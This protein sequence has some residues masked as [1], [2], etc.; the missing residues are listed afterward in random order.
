MVLKHSA[1]IY[2]AL[3][4]GGWSV[5]T[6]LTHDDYDQIFMVDK[7][8]DNQMKW[9]KSNASQTQTRNKIFKDQV[10]ENKINSMFIAGLV[11]RYDT[12]NDF[13]ELIFFNVHTGLKKQG[14]GSILMSRFIEAV[15]AKKLRKIVV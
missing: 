5:D 12:E 6:Y 14:Y 2:E 1:I 13:A 9:E 11:C 8:A 7:E 15:R 10:T 3:R 4:D